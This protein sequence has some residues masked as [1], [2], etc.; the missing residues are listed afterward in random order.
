MGLTEQLA[1]RAAGLRFED[2]PPDVVQLARQC[3]LDWFGV[4]VA[5][6]REPAAQIVLAE[7]AEEGAGTSTVV[8]HRER[9][10]ASTAALVNGTASHALDYD[11]VNTA[12]TGHP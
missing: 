7:A 12:M 6:S 4:T 2:I 9:L 5:G 10:P 3:A 1:A 11:D 8:G